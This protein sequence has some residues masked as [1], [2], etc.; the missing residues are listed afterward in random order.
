M[1]SL[2]RDFAS[3]IVDDKVF[4]VE[5]QDCTFFYIYGNRW[6]SNN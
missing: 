2:V 6:E 3:G 5:A 1:R 4:R